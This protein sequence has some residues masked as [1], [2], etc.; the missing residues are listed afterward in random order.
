[1]KASHLNSKHQ[2]EKKLYFLH[3]WNKSAD[4]LSSEVHIAPNCLKKLFEENLQ[5]DVF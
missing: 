5:K 3:P 2:V 1:M 4:K